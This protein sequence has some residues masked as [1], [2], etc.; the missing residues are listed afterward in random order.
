MPGSYESEKAARFAFEFCDDLLA[1][2]RD[3][4]VA[5]NNGVIT[6]KALDTMKETRGFSCGQG[7]HREGWKQGDPIVFDDDRRI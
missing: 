6:E 4:A 2:L 1:K 7:A 3:D 5:M